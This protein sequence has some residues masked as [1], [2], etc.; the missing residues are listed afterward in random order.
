[1]YRPEH[2]VVPTELYSGT[3]KCQEPSGEKE[4]V[5]YV[6]DSIFGEQ[7]YFFDTD[8]GIQEINDCVHAHVVTEFPGSVSMNNVDL[9]QGY[10]GQPQGHWEL[11]T[12]QRKKDCV[13]QVWSHSRR[14]IN[15]VMRNI[16]TIGCCTWRMVRYAEGYKITSMMS[17]IVS[18]F[19]TDRRYKASY[20]LGY[21]SGCSGQGFPGSP[22]RLTTSLR[23]VLPA[24]M[25]LPG[26]SLPPLSSQLGMDVDECYSLGRRTSI[27]CIE[28]MSEFLV[29][30][31][32][33]TVTSGKYYTPLEAGALIPAEDKPFLFS[34][35][36][37]IPSQLPDL[38]TGNPNMYWKNW[39]VQHAYLAACKSVPTLNDNS[40]SNVIEIVSFIKGLV[41]DHKISFPK[42]LQDAWL[43]YRYSF[44]TTKLDIDE[45]IKFASRHMRLGTLDVKLKCY[46]DATTVVNGTF[47][48]CR[49]TLNITPQQLGFVDK[50]WRSLTTYGLSPSFYVV[51]D[52]IPFSFIVDWFIPVGDVLSVVDAENRF[53]EQNY[54]IT[55]VCF[56]L[57]YVREIGTYAYKVYSRWRSD[58]LR[59][60][61][62][63]YWFDKPETSDKTKLYRIL[64]AVSLAT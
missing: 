5:I 6:A 3:I 13:Y 28:S 10:V 47:V 12:V 56:S 49:C 9:G 15:G 58:A 21:L 1:M 30:D 53:S 41:V 55:D 64:D 26:S 31:T 33:E 8:R 25:Y 52:M 48:T 24:G 40:I 23:Y 39:L 16:L 20:E 51:W 46:G 17:A 19:L 7:D 27:E 57:S 62:G 32:T 22:V 59:S 18:C 42:R 36:V 44:G 50:L 29:M 14:T 43:A 37:V 61:N 63:F 54:S 35:D 34:E 45:A 11:K 38:V 2:I 4:K 60:L